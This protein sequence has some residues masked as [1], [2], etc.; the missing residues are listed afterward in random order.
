MVKGVG[1][2]MKMDLMMGADSGSSHLS[3]WIY[4]ALLTYLH[5]SMG[6]LVCHLHFIG[7]KTEAHRE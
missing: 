4:M 6:E 1:V 7:E 3:T 5:N 2:V